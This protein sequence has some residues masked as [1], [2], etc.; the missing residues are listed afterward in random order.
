MRKAA[1]FLTVISFL[2]T[3]PL[4]AETIR[5]SPGLSVELS[6][7]GERWTLALKAP[8]FLLEETAEHLEHE[9]AAQG[10]H[11]DSAK[12]KAAAAKRLAANE[13]FIFN[14]ASGAVMTLDFSPL[15]EGEDP[16][17]R[18]TVAASARY[19]GDSLASEE[20]V[21]EVDMKTV[22]KMV[23]GAEHAHGVEARYRHHGEP[24]LFVGIVGFVNPHWFFFYYTDPLK[25]PHDAEDMNTILESLILTSVR[26]G[27]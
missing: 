3:C 26:G 27:K 1:F 16:P 8:D 22:Q 13:V 12:L 20:G 17:G 18:K 15:R 19:A 10:K 23:V 9:L 7:P 5:I 2:W 25:D 21:S 14:P 11:V 4:A 24:T 6:I